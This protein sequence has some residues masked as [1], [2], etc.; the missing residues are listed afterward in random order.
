MHSRISI[1]IFTHWVLTL[2]HYSSATAALQA[3]VTPAPTNSK[4]TKIAEFIRGTVKI[5]GV[6]CKKIQYSI[7]G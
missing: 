1:A 2:T 3:F 6:R 7:M 4:S 5:Q